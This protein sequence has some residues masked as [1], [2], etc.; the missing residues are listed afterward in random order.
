MGW[1]SANRI[2]DPTA[3]AL[4]CSDASDEEI[5]DVLHT[6]ILEL[7][8]GDWDTLDESIEEFREYPAVIEA[9]RRA[10]PE[11]LEEDED[12]YEDE[13][14]ACGPGCEYCYPDEA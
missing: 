3:R 2:F 12:E 10:A 14:P 4:V 9:F 13:Y 11:W 6:L 1:N 5:T 8:A 7:M